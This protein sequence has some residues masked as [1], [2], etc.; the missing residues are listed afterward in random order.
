MISNDIIDE[1]I[2]VGKHLYEKDLTSGTSGNI[3]VRSSDGIYITVSGSSLADLTQE[4]IVLIDYCGREI[5]NGKK[6]SSE[7]FL[8]TEIYRLR[9]DINA[10]IHCHPPFAGAFAVAHL[11]LDKPNLA[12]NV[13]YFGKIPLAAYGMPSSEKLVDNTIQYF[14]KYNTVLMANHGIVSGEST[15]KKAFYQIE[16]AENYAKITMY[17][18][19]LGKEVLLDK[20]AVKDLENLKKELK[21]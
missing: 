19:I 4:D 14:D 10:V 17:S 1:I 12:E 16:T 15:L 9:N 11:E 3:S 8:H 6:A 20:T 7:R 18:K 13:L 2:S 21:S 5:E